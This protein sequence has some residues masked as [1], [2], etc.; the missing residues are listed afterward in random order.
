L[1]VGVYGPWGEGKTSL[2]HMVEDEL[3]RVREA[4]TLWFNPWYFRGQEALILSFFAQLAAK[5]EVRLGTA[6]DEFKRVL[7]KYG[8]V[9]SALPLSVYGVDPGKVMTAVGDRLK[10]SDLEA[11]KGRLETILDEKHIELVVFMDDI[12]RL[13]RTEIH[14]V[15]KLVKLAAGFR[16]V[17]YVLSFDDDMV[18][19]AVGE[20]YG[21]DTEAGRNFLEKIVQVPLRLP[22]VDDGTVLHLTLGEVDRALALTRSELPMEQVQE[23]RR[24]FDPFFK[25]RPR[26]LRGG[27]RYGNALAFALPL[28]EGEARVGDLLLLEALRAFSP[29]VYSAIAMQRALLL[30]REAQEAFGDAQR[31]KETSLAAWNALLD[32]AE[33]DERPALADLL[34]HL[35]PRVERFTHNT[36]YGSEW[37]TRWAAEQR[38]AS[39]DYFDRYFQ[40]SVPPNDVSD[41][42]VQA[43]V[44]QLATGD[45][46]AAVARFDALLSAGNAAR[47]IRKLRVKEGALDPEVAKTLIRDLVRRGGGLPRPRTFLGSDVPQVQ[48][49]YLLAAA[50]RRVRAA[51]RYTVAEEVISEPTALGFAVEAFR[52]IRHIESDGQ[53]TRARIVPAE[54][55]SRLRDILR[56]RLT[57]TARRHPFYLDE[58]ED[59]RTLLQ[60]WAWLAGRDQTDPV[61][62]ERFVRDPTEAAKVVAAL[63]GQPWS[64]TT[65]LPL[66]PEIER[67]EY[68]TVARLVDPAVVVDAMRKAYGEDLGAASDD[69]VEGTESLAVQTGT[70]LELRLARRFL[71]LHKKVTETTATSA[72]GAT[73][74]LSASDG[75]APRG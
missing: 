38:V 54:E 46:E 48:A 33:P 24:Y 42:G 25:A 22:R 18:A 68:D 10:G 67:E 21:G 23:F 20:A 6:A 43:L 59:N 60:A 45:V 29:T 1:V 13:D 69:E 32:L 36:H 5:L 70:S 8:G 30:G 14:A 66:P 4:E 51:D 65:G 31:R 39:G 41:V 74:T 56:D 7:N 52:R 28:L 34:A 61:L 75:E 64:M 57:A 3:T 44:E 15:L 49:V 58:G 72:G 71:Y 27:K 63:A 17:T 40:Y 55:E 35:F 50:M 11:L 16:H 47:L 9:L 12:D 73:A 2:L 53:P 26:T 62:R 19:A 37:D